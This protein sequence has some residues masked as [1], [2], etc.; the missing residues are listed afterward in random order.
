MEA[1]NASVDSMLGATPE[2]MQVF[3]KV[4]AE[5]VA[6]QKFNTDTP[7]VKKCIT[8]KKATRRSLFV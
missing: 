4:A 1:A 8:Q 5:Y 2:Q 7:E 6:A 3:N